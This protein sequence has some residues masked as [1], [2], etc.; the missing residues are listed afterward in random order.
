MDRRLHTKCNGCNDISES[1]KSG[2]SKCWIIDSTSQKQWGEVME[3]WNSRNWGNKSGGKCIQCLEGC[4]Q[5]KFGGSSRADVAAKEHQQRLA[6]L[7][8]MSEQNLDSIT[9]DVC[10]AVRRNVRLLILRCLRLL[11]DIIQSFIRNFDLIFVSSV[12]YCKTFATL[13][14]LCTGN[15]FKSG[16]ILLLLK[17]AEQINAW[18]HMYISAWLLIQ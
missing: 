1:E 3:S 18:I 12:T 13:V 16:F 17:N 10:N 9:P 2:T 5:G 6:T 8:H 14:I 4:S 7:A 15:T 11:L